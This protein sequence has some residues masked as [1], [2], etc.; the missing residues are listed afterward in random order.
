[1]RDISCITF[2]CYGTLV[3]W[4]SGIKSA[5]MDILDEKRSNVNADELYKTREDL[6]FDLIQSEYRT[7]REILAL[8]LKETFNQYR[9][10]YSN[11]DGERLIESV[12]RWPV[13][14]E[15]KPTLESL[16]KKYRLC[17][18]SNV[19]N[20]IIGRTRDRIGVRFDVIVTAQDARAYKPNS[21]PFQIALQRL[22]SKPT[23]VLHVSSGFRYDI[24]PAHQ[25]GMRTAWINRKHEKSFSQVK[26]DLEF[27][28][29]EEL[30]QFDKRTSN[31]HL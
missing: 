26:P 21:R 31:P 1:M 13:F 7:Y 8:S 9:I 2:D 17:I 14:H 25:V 11:A 5:L 19:D 22:N 12:P 23:E 27:H 10:P 4:E 16:A 29:L 24:P 20:D 18:I 28:N 3:D 15:T 30:A 6:E